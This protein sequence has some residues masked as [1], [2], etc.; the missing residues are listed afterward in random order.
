MDNFINLIENDYGKQ[1]QFGDSRYYQKGDKWFPGITE[2]LNTLSK[3]KQYEMWLKSNGFNADILARQAMNEGSHVHEA[4][5]DL[6]NGKEVSFMGATQN[7]YNRREWQIINRFM[8]FY[9]EWKPKIIA[10]EKVLVSEKLGF[11]SQ[12]DLIIE[13]NN[14]IW[15]IDHKTGAIYDTAYL[16]TSAYVKL[17]EEYFPKQKIKKV[18]ILHLDSAHR[19]RDAKGKSIQGQGW[20]LIE[21]EDTEKHY[22]DFQH[23]LALWNRS[24]PDYKPFI[25]TYPATLKL[26]KDND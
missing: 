26:N 9:N 16:Q 10:V 21:V 15:L 12:I 17:W 7:N 19:G 20:K 3:G 1:V 22:G 5:Q 11:G 8:D 24:N 2:V 4:I 6:C 13:L 23:I 25:L 14:E 18:G